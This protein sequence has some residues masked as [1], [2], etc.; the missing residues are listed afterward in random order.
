MNALDRLRQAGHIP[1]AYSW[2]SIE[3]QALVDHVDRLERRITELEA[4]ARRCAD[5]GRG[6]RVLIAT[7]DSDGSVVYL[8]PGCS[9]K[10]MQAIH[11]RAEALPL[12]GA[13]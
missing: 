5:C 8:G 3:A 10:R 12:G 9:R 1:D 7:Q 4:A 11:R 13:R 2:A 6:A